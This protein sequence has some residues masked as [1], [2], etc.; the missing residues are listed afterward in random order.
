MPSRLD[1]PGDDAQALRQTTANYLREVAATAGARFSGHWCWDEFGLWVPPADPRSAFAEARELFGHCTA[2]APEPVEILWR[3]WGE[4]APAW[5][6]MN[7]AE[8]LPSTAQPALRGMWANPA[9][10]MVDL[11]DVVAVRPSFSFLPLSCTGTDE[12]N[13]KPSFLRPAMDPR[14]LL[15]QLV[16][17][18]EEAR[19]LITHY[20]HQES[21]R[22]GP[23][24]TTIDAQAAAAR[25][26]LTTIITTAS[27]GAV[28]TDVNI[29]VAVRDTSVDCPVHRLDPLPG[30]VGPD[31]DRIAGLHLATHV[32]QDGS[33]GLEDC[34]AGYLRAVLTCVALYGGSV[35]LATVP[36]AGDPVPVAEEVLYRVHYDWRVER[37]E[38]PEQRQIAYLNQ[39]LTTRDRTA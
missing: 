24:W 6:R 25:D 33:V 19:L 38:D 37:V 18:D 11:A 20:L 5:Y 30:Y 21:H 16:I 28:H 13:F 3:R 23:L 17:S 27:A 39:M 7:I 15:P 1:E 14:E 22:V 35:H 32:H 10:G 34:E 26:Q 12:S 8:V 4:G 29:T 2:D 36:L 9:T 31:E